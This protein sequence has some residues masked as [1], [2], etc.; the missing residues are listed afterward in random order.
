MVKFMEKKKKKKKLSG[1][2]DLIILEFIQNMYNI[3]TR[4]SVHQITA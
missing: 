4:K 1:H 2:K 3:C